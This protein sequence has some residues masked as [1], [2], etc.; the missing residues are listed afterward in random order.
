ML[1][2]MGSQRVGHDL[3]TELNFSWECLPYGIS[4]WIKK[5]DKNA[6]IMPSF[7]IVLL[8]RNDAKAESPVF[9]PPHTKS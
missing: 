4:G 7:D 8:G 3:A 5:Q 9:W 1:Q 6:N 2:F